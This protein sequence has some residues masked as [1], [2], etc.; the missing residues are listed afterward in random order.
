M[1]KWLHDKVARAA[2]KKGLKGNRFKAYVFS[3]LR[4]YK[5]SHEH[6]GKK[7]KQVAKP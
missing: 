2:R 7:G 6:K 1:P 3:T 5:V 4:D